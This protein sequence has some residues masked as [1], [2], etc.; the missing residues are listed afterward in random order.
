[1]TRLL[2][3]KL[4]AAAVVCSEGRTFMKTILRVAFGTALALRVVFGTVPADATTFPVVAPGDPFS[5]I[6]TLDPSTPCGPASGCQPPFFFEWQDPGAIAIALGGQI[7]AAPI[8]RVDRSVPFFSE[9]PLW[10]EDNPHNRGTINGEAVG[11][12]YINLLLVDITGSTSIFPP[13]LP[14][15]PPQLSVRPFDL[16]IHA[17]LCSNPFFEGGVK[18]LIIMVT[19][20]HWS[21]SILQGILPSAEL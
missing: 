13:T 19:L 3:S 11:F 16:L 21:R 15:Y 2:I 12:L 5:G 4:V 18:Y 7:F 17:A 10:Q 20:R 14:P 9:L 6:L 1:M 8:E